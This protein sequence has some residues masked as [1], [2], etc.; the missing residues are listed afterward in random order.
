V[1]YFIAQVHPS[2][3]FQNNV[4]LVRSNSVDN[5]AI[6]Q[7][8]VIK[9]T[10]VEVINCY[11]LDPSRMRKL[12]AV[13]YYNSRYMHVKRMRFFFLSPMFLQAFVVV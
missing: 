13:R 1:A 5:F 2:R 8:P 11:A 3:P 4:W 9:T 6:L 10:G 12:K 7:T